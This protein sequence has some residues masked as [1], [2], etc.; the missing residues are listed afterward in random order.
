MSA[1]NYS[2]TLG[3]AR[4]LLDRLERELGV[5]S[6]EEVSLGVHFGGVGEDHV[7]PRPEPQGPEGLLKALLERLPHLFYQHALLL[8]PGLRNTYFNKCLKLN[9]SHKFLSY[10]PSN[11]RARFCERWLGLTNWLS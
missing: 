9:T 2:K 10:A 4:D 5:E 1:N 6:K 7:P 8:L 11:G 3:S